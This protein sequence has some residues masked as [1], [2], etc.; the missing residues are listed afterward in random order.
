[1]DWLKESLKQ[2]KERLDNMTD[3]KRKQLE[4]M[5]EWRKATEHHHNYDR[6]PEKL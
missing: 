4:L 3:E 5:E 6:S 1:M 2:S